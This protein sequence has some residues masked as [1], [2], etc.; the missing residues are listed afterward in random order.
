MY[1]STGDNPGPQDC[2]LATKNN[3]RKRSEENILDKADIAASLPNNDYMKASSPHLNLSSSSKENNEILKKRE[4]TCPCCCCGEILMK[5]QVLE[6]K[7]A[8]EPFDSTN[9]LFIWH[10]ISFFGTKFLFLESIEPNFLCAEICSYK[11]KTTVLK[12]L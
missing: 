7:M 3:Q 2:V 4:F 5:F 11:V 12:I 1:F 6:S 10:E 8:K 9:F